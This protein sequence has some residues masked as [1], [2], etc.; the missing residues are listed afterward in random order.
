MIRNVEH[1]HNDCKIRLVRTCALY[2]LI[3]SSCSHSS[4]IPTSLPPHPPPPPPPSTS[5]KIFPPCR[6]LFLIHPS[7]ITTAVAHSRLLS[8]SREW[9]R[10]PW[11]GKIYHWKIQPSVTIGYP[12]HQSSSLS[13][14]LSFTSS[15]PTHFNNQF[16]SVSDNH[17]SPFLFLLSLSSHFSFSSQYMK[18]IYILC[19]LKAR[20]HY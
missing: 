13:L 6:R 18:D 5:Y 8:S 19:S 17:F 4:L 14:S 10:I 20:T 12:R 7:N 1:Q 3:C 16:R 11:R 9:E 15:S 2:S